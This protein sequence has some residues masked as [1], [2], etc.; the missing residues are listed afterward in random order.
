[1]FFNYYIPPGTPSILKIFVS[2]AHNTNIYLPRQDK[3]V[4]LPA[5]HT[6]NR[7]VAFKPEI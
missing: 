5:A 3:F 7:T 6:T 4:A 1:M 2:H